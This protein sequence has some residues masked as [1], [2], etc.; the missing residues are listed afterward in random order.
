M[1]K[2]YITEHQRPS[3]SFGNLMPVPRMPPLA[4]QVVSIGGA[5]AQSDAFSASSHMIGVHTDATCSVE[6]GVDPTATP[7]SRRLA[8]NT[9]EYFEVEAGKSMRLA[10]ISNS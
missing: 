3:V 10:V 2:V 4:S 1:A 7:S 9:T 8:A 5:S 6:F